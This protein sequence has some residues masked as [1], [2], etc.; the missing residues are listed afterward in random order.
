MKNKDRSL[1]IERA[2]AARVDA[3][4]E[5]EREAIAAFTEF[6]EENADLL[7]RVAH[8]GNG[9]CGALLDI[10]QRTLQPD[11]KDGYQA[12]PAYRKQV[13]PASIRTKV[14][15]RDAYRCVSCAGFVELTCDHKFPE[16]LGGPTTI[17]NLQTLC[18]SCNS[19]KGT[20]VPEADAK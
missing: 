20:R 7:R 9:R 4:A 13:I 5:L 1:D 15:E 10:L 17:D 8:W 3:E 19:R 12:R 11:M 2:R 16:S 14:F 6:V 18:R